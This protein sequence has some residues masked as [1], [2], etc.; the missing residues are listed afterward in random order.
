MPLW[1]P[2]YYE[3]AP[4]KKYGAVFV[5][6]LDPDLN[7]ARVEF[8]EKLSARTEVLIM[9]GSYPD[10]FPHS[11]IV[12]NQTVKG[13]LN[14][15]IFES[16]MCGALLLTERSGNGLLEL[17]EDGKHLITYQKNNVEEAAE[18]IEYY[19]AHPEEAR[20]IAAA[21]RE[22]ILARHCSRHRAE[23]IEEIL[24]TIYKKSTSGKRYPW[25]M[26]FWALSR[27]LAT[28]DIALSKKALLIALRV[29]ELGLKQKEPINQE[30]AITLV[31]ACARYDWIMHCDGG[32]VLLR[33]MI[34]Q[35]PEQSIFCLAVIRA[36]LNRGEIKQ[37]EM[38]ASALIEQPVAVTF[39]A[40]EK[41]ME[42]VFLTDEEQMWKIALPE[43]Q[44]ETL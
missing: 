10:I 37:A 25:M 30:E 42:S 35:Y 31:H 2:K 38:L 27:R 26:N 6:T 23:R 4:Q 20:R 21:G 22:E 11:E 28:L 13:D 32:E 12:I 43:S 34:D 36:H 3:P 18:K 44:N 19:L 7:P 24:T 1:A 9:Q 14:F 16:M 8:F 17:F 33:K 40:A 29:A 5:G 39:Q 41:V 15:R